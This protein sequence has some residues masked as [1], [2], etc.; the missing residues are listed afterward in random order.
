[1][2][3]IPLF[4]DL[5]QNPF[6][7]GLVCNSFVERLVNSYVQGLAVKSI[8][9]LVVVPLFK[10]W[11]LPFSLM[12]S[13]HLFVLGPA[14]ISYF[15]DQLLLCLCS[16]TGRNPFAQGQTVTPLLKTGSNSFDQI[17]LSFKKWS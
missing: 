11:M 5:L 1:M 15:K 3:A 8:F 2:V 16:V 12:I 9:R 10:D 14:D 6:V 4:K 7:Q 13:C 17:F